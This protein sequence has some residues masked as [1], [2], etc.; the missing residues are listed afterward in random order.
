MTFLNPKAIAIGAVA[1]AAAIAY[2]IIIVNSYKSDILD[3]KLDVAE[4]TTQNSELST[5]N[6]KFGLLTDTQNKSISAL[7]LANKS[8]SIV[9]SQALD[10][11]AKKRPQIVKEIREL[12]AQQPTNDPSKDCDTATKNLQ[13]YFGL[14]G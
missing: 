4:L 3:L 6:T 14:K 12:Q 11:A 13:N 2:H 8:A 7:I 9:A 5:S 10:I 1:I